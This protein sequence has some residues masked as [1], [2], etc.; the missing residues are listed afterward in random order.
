[1]EFLFSGCVKN[2]SWKGQKTIKKRKGFKKLKWDNKRKERCNDWQRKR[3]KGSGRGWEG[4]AGN[5]GYVKELTWR[6]TTILIT[7][8]I[9]VLP[10]GCYISSNKNEK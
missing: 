5:S 6:I 9:M 4:W 1:M 3:M 7:V 10:A 8:I 2:S